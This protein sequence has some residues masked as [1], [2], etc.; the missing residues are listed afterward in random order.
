MEIC[1]HQNT[2]T[3]YMDS[4]LPPELVCAGQWGR[5]WRTGWWPECVCMSPCHPVRRE[6]GS[7]LQPRR[8]RHPA[9]ALH[10][11]AYKHQHS[12]SSDFL[13]LNQVHWI[14]VC[15]PPFIPCIIP[16]NKL[17]TC[18]YGDDSGRGHSAVAESNI[19]HYIWPLLKEHVH[20]AGNNGNVVLFAKWLFKG[21]AVLALINTK[22][23][24]DD[25]PD[26]FV[27]FYTVLTFRCVYSRG[28][29]YVNHDLPVEREGIA[30]RSH[31]IEKIYRCIF[32]FIFTAQPYS[33]LIWHLGYSLRM[34]F[35]NPFLFLLNLKRYQ[36]L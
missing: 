27:W 22:K 29:Q 26:L 23:H 3:C 8:S 1:V 9:S 36:K 7:S 12:K 14:K 11:T 21:W 16:A 19:L 17:V 5:I 20:A 30:V 33:H 25:F 13:Q 24:K 4:I 34:G 10:S 31:D 18:C 28:A 2:C 32:I 6:T 35:F 15:N